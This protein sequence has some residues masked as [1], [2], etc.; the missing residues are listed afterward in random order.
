MEP[1]TPGTTKNDTVNHQKD[2]NPKIIM[3]IQNIKHHHTGIIVK[4]IIYCLNNMEPKTP[5]TTKNYP[6]NMY[7]K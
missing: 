4:Y 7:P 6:R 5:G 3:F 2:I 1:K